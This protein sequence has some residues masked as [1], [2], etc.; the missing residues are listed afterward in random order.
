MKSKASAHLSEIGAM[1]AILILS[2]VVGHTFAIYGI[3]GSQTWHLPKQY[4]GID[5]L[6][7]VNPAF[8]SFS[9]QAFV[10]ISGYL[11]RMST[12]GRQ[13]DKRKFLKKKVKRLF[14]PLV[15]FGLLYWLIIDSKT[16]ISCYDCLNY[17]LSGAGH[18]WFLT[19]LL[20]CFIAMSL[21]LELQNWVLVSNS[22]KIVMSVVLVALYFYSMFAPS[23]FRL[24]QFC[25]YF[26]YFVL[27]YWT[28]DYRENLKN[29]KWQLVLLMC[30][31]TV[32]G[33]S[34]KLYLV[35]ERPNHYYV[36]NS[37]NDLLLGIAGSYSMLMLCLKCREGLYLNEIGLWNGFFGVY[38]F[39]QFIL[40][41]LY[42]KTDLLIGVNRCC[43]GLISLLLTL[44]LS[45][46][47]SEIF[48][49][50]KITRNLI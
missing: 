24:A 47:L 32:V 2:I 13:I 15:V 14:V 3:E 48:L 49:R 7:W 37:M 33:I 18:L 36:L 1:R 43:V 6:W 16:F 4:E 28:F 35:W 17:F 45:Y 44:F 27:G 23:D 11:M 10:F 40:R 22:R 26:I 39:H 12:V 5:F 9:L 41:F 30:L 8:I 31:L 29:V 42:Y 21:S 25:A 34:L 46:I 38:I 50:Y 20:M 19:M